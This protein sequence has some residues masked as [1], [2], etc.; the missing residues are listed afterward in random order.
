MLIWFDFP[1]ILTAHRRAVRIQIFNSFIVCTSLIRNDLD[2]EL[3]PFSLH[4]LYIFC[5]WTGARGHLA[6]G[7]L[8]ILSSLST[9]LRSTYL[10]LDTKECSHLLGLPTQIFLPLTE[11]YWEQVVEDSAPPP[12]SPWS[13]KLYQMGGPERV[14]QWNC[15]NITVLIFE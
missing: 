5:P 2:W 3:R 13:S 11:K 8:S 12:P 7:H 10:S 6:R 14:N 15:Y 4:S 9:F 1:T